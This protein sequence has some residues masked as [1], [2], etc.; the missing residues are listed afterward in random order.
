MKTKNVMTHQ[1]KKEKG[2]ISQTRFV[3]S[4]FLVSWVGLLSGCWCF[5]GEMIV[6]YWL[7]LWTGW[8]LWW[9]C[10]R[11]L[12]TPAVCMSLFEFEFEFEFDFWVFFEPSSSFSFSSPNNCF[13]WSPVFGETCAYRSKIWDIH[14][15]DLKSISVF[16]GLNFR[17]ILEWTD[18]RNKFGVRRSGI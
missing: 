9:W 4:V 3:A 13:A 1:H 10:M 18:S 11:V 6:A 16:G 2:P 5:F 7:R 17:F 14:L 15:K 8:F 12:N